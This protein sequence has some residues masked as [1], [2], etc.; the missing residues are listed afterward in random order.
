MYTPEVAET[1]RVACGHACEARYDKAI[2]LLTPVIQ[3]DPRC[4]DGLEIRAITYRKAGRFTDA[5]NDF[6]SL[7]KLDP[8]NASYLCEV[9]HA[10]YRLGQ[11][12][13]ALHYAARARLLAPAS[14]WPFT[15]IA[16]IRLGGEFYTDVLAR[17]IDRVKPRTYVE[18]GVFKGDS[19]RLALP[20][21]RAIGIDPA[22]R[23]SAPLAENQKVFAE[24]SDAFFASHDLRAEL[25][26][27]PV[28]LAFID[29]MHQFEF[30]LRDFANLERHCTRD[31]IILIHDCYPLDRQSAE[32]TPQPTNWS[33]DVWRLIV[34]LKKYRPD[35]AIAT[36]GA[37]PTGLALIRNLDPASRILLDRHDELCAEFLALDYAY[38]DEGM[39]EKLNYVPND[40]EKIRALLD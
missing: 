32:R 3:R 5:V 7:E 36:L 28:D 25:D 16:Q 31:S 20:P 39:R 4:V 12:R 23:L 11:H 33:G 26:G 6:L 18:I 27:L 21:T 14:P 22:P 9:A 38:L 1:L 8:N 17:I 30:A 15:L 13:R 34:L 40:W 37:P 24:T 29:G 2:A 10:A 19:L 35:L